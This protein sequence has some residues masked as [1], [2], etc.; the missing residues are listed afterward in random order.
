MQRIRRLLVLISASLS[1]CLA[2]ALADSSH[3]EAEPIT[4]VFGGDVALCH[5]VERRMDKYGE[6][7]VFEA[8]RELLAQAD[9][10]AVNLEAPLTLSDRKA[11]KPTPPGLKEPVYLK[12]KPSAAK[13]LSAGG[14]DV[15]FLANNHIADY[16]GAVLD[17]VRALRGLGIRPVGAGENRREAYQPTVMEVRGVRI[18]FL[19]FCDIYPTSYEAGDSRPGCAWAHPDAMHAAIAEAKKQADVVFVNLHFG[20]QDATIPSARQRQLAKT[21]LDAGADMVVGNHPHVIQPL[22]VDKGRPVLFSLGNLAFSMPKYSWSIG[23]VARATIVKKRVQRVDLTP[24]QIVDLAQPR[25]IHGHH[26][27]NHLYQ[28]SKEFGDLPSIKE[29]YVEPQQ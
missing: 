20:G 23:I 16:K 22:A 24:I 9:I 29:G 7:Y 4:V 14:I 1:L 19:A 28:I 26:V 8:I 5:E 10:A 12:A 17:T 21:A 27:L 18:A 13:A 11:P 15:A 25:R 6:G 2:I 3:T